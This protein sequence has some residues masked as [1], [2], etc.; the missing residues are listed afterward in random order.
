MGGRWQALEEGFGNGGG[1]FAAGRAAEAIALF[2]EV[3]ASEPVLQIADR[4]WLVTRYDDARAILRNPR[5]SSNDQVALTGDPTAASLADPTRYM[6]FQDPPHH[7][8]LRALV[9]Q[10]FSP[11]RIRQM[12]ADVERA[13]DVLLD[14]VAGAGTMDLIAELARPLPVNVICAMLD[15]PEADRESIRGYAE[16][17]SL[18]LD[19]DF[20]DEA[21]LARA[22]SGSQALRDYF[23]ILIEQ[24]RKA[25][26]D[27]IL[28]DLIAAE[29]AGSTLST[30]EI[31]TM[32]DLLFVAGHETTVNLIGNGMLAMLETP[33]SL[34]R[35]AAEPD[36]IPLAV[37]ESLRFAPSVT[38]NGRYALEDLPV[39][40]TVIPMGHEVFIPLDAVNRDPARFDDPHR[41]D[42]GRRENPHLTFSIGPHVCLGAGL[43]RLEARVVWRRM[44]ARLGGWRLTA[45]VRYREHITLRGLEALPV[46]FAAAS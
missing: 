36:T 17:S 10:A 5:F 4:L 7:T 29:E 1:I 43:A 22:V 2:D 34:E 15:V 16:D 19:H 31:V 45:P 20:I 33:G 40:G 18:L 41:F 39:G 32:A 11:R 8:R 14:A 26:G 23:R 13:V 37:E 12:E 46:A 3:R 35:M 28:S 27:D 24:R 42:V 25:P 30:E 44:L 21:T 38:L 9:Q 6:L